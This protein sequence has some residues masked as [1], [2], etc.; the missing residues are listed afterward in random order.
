MKN[1]KKNVIL[2]LVQGFCPLKIKITQVP[3]GFHLNLFTGRS[4]LLGD[5]T[6]T[7]A[8]SINEALT[9]PK[10]I[11]ENQHSADPLFASLNSQITSNP[12]VKL[13]DEPI[14]NFFNPEVQISGKIPSGGN[15]GIVPDATAAS[16]A[17]VSKATGKLCM[18]HR[19][20]TMVFCQI[21]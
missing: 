6:E 20:P 18:V 11:S 16:R 5:N 1:V 3:D 14:D 17:E 15:S 7:A 21:H 12:E 13:N 19:H 10:I 9:S 2:F 8:A 4:N